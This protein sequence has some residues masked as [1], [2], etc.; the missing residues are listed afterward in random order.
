MT[1]PPKD[2]RTWKI[3]DHGELTVPREFL[4]AAGLGPKMFVRF[5]VDGKSIVVE[6]ASPSANPL[7]A[8]LGKKVDS[9]LFSKIQSE[10]AREKERLREKFEKGLRETPKD[11]DEPPDHPFRWD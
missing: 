9:D 5:K 2:P 11:G 6:K 1:V 8:P 3:G 4:E 10:A 7:D